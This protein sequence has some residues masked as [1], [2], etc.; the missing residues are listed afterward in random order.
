MASI[1]DSPYNSKEHEDKIYKLWEKSGFFNPD[2][3]IKKGITSK[4]APYFSIALPPPNVTGTLHLGHAF[5]HTL[6]DTMIRYHRMK[7]ERTLWIPGTDHAAIATQAKYEKE[8]YKKEKKSRHDFSREEFF[9]CVHEFALKNQS[10]ILS[11][12]KQLGDSLDWSR[13]AFTL[14]KDSEYAVREAFK[15]MNDDG[16]IYRGNRIVNWDPKGQTTISDDEVVYEEAD[17]A[18][19]TFRYAKDFPISIATT[20][21][22]TKVGDVA[23]AV[24]PDDARYKKYVGKEYDAVFC[25][26]PIH[27]QIVADKEVDPAF[28]TGAVGLTPAHSQTDWDIADRHDLSHEV[29][30]INEIAKMTV[31]GR[32]QG[33]K[34]AEAQDMVVEWLQDEGLLEKEE[35]I[36]QNVATAE[37]TGGIIEPLP[38]LQWFVEVNKEVPGRG[39]TLKELMLEPVRSGQI[40]I[41]PEHFEKTYFHWIENLRDWCISRQIWYGHRIPV[42]YKQ[43]TEEIKVGEGPSVAEAMEGTWIQ[44]EDT[45]DTWFSSSSW[46]FST[47]G[48]PDAT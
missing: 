28:G 30:V 8:L 37:R 4:D 13:L 9:W 42:W 38:K 6:Q 32:L 46:T 12:F 19:Y 10:Q 27:I 24:H 15:R 45:L 20:R 11:Q 5:E 7:G 36:Q 29:A 26:V 47:L 22:E 31:E 35:D 39:K 14:D 23:V 18:L 1:F 41:I 17:G 48:W 44:D 21:P 25:D 40:K 16:L 2:V 3:C 43:G 33:K 34:T